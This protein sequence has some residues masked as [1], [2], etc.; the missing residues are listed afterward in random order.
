SGDM[1]APAVTGELDGAARP[2][3][4][5]AVFRGG[6]RLADGAEEMVHRVID[7]AGGLA[8][9]RAGLIRA[10]GDSALRDDPLRC[11]RAFRLAGQLGF[12]LEAGTVRLIQ[13]AAPGLVRCAGE[14]IC[15]ELVAILLL[16]S[17]A[18][19]VRE[20]EE[21]ASLWSTIFPFL[22]PLQGMEQGGHHVDDVWEHSLKTLQYFEAMVQSGWRGGECHRHGDGDRGLLVISSREGK[23]AAGQVEHLAGLVGREYLWQPLAGGRPRLFLLKLACLL[24]DAGKQFCRR[25]AGDGKYIFYSHH[26]LGRPLAL[27]AAR[28]LR[29]SRRE[30]ELLAL[31]VEM[32]MQPLFLYKNSA[33]GGLPGA[34]AL[35]RLYRRAGDE[36][37]GLLA[38]SLADVASS[39]LT[40][41]REEDFDLYRQF[42]G[43]LWRH[44]RRQ[45]GAGRPPRL[46]NGRDIC[47]LLGVRPGPLVG[48]LLEELA[49]AQLEG[50]VRDRAQAEAL[51]RQLAGEI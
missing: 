45:V 33:P 24:H 8:D 48:R 30:A 51:V 17:A 36:L 29:L 35:H 49:V 43:R 6:M 37:P 21:A 3:A 4:A 14:R 46:L 50:R 23:N 25:Y 2:A 12:A 15:A 10:V 7:P 31:L 22:A 18:Q 16:P 42:I 34:R 19:R 40:A 1:A 47:R 13:E 39:R 28:R 5:G 38:L 11:L 44:Y 9:L 20:M 26:Q 32:H 41:G 27:E